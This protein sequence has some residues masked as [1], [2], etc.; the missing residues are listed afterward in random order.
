MYLIEINEWRLFE[1]SVKILQTKF[2]QLLMVL[3]S[4]FYIFIMIGIRIWGG[5]IN[6]R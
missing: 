3:Y 2:F 5:K 4:I 6:S 1:K